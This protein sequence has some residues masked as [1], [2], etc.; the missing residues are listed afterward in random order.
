[1]IA[2]KNGDSGI[3]EEEQKQA[4]TVMAQTFLNMSICYFLQENYR[5]AE[6]RALESIKIMKTIKAHYRRARALAALKD[7]WGACND[8]KEAIKMDKTDPNDFKRELAQYTALGKQKDK[9]SDNK[10][11]GFLNKTQELE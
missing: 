6:Q 7:Y 8:L 1:M 9:K 4:Q 10:L 11:R 5:R 2:E 3:T